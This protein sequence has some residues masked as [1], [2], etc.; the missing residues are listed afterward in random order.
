MSGAEAALLGVGI[1]CNAM[2]IITFAKDSIHVYRNIRDGRA[3]DP[4]LDSYLK[5]SKA[6]FHEMN[7]TAAQIGPLSQTQQQIFDV[8]KKVHDCVDELQQQFARLHVDEGSKRR[9]R[10]RIAAS[11]KS[12]VALWR[13]KELQDAEKNLQRHEQLLHSLLLDRVC[14]QSQAA[15]V[16]S[17]ESFQHL[18]G[19]LQ[20]IISQLAHGSTDVSDLVT[21]FSAN[22]SNQVADEHTTTRT[23]IEDHIASAE[24]TIRQSM[25]QSIDQ[26]RQ[27]LLERE[28]DKAFEKQYERLLSSLRFPDMNRRKHHISSNYP[29]TF[30][31]ILDQD[32]SHQSDCGSSS[33]SDLSDTDSQLSEDTRDSDSGTTDDPGF[34]SF[35]DWLESDSSIFWISGKPG[36]G[37]SFL[38][39]F[40]ASNKQTMDCLKM[41]QSNVRIITHFF[42]KPGQL[43]QR[44]VEGMVL[45]LLYQVMEGKPGL[46]RKLYT[47]QPSVQYK[48]S[49]SDWSLDELTEALIWAL[50]ASPEA[51]CIF[52][53]G[54]DEAKELEHLPWPDWT[55]AQVIHKLL[56]LDD[57]KLCASS[58][59]EH[60]FC[61]FFK[62]ASRL[63]MQQFNNSDITLYVRERLDICGLECRDRDRLVQEIVRKAQGV[64]MWV[65]LIVDRLNPAIR[66]RSANI[67]MLQELLRQTPSDLTTLYTDM[68]GRIGDDGKLPSIQVTAS[69]YFNLLFVAREIDE[70]LSKNGLYSHPA[71]IRMSSLLVMATAAQNQPTETILNTGRV[72]R[73]EDLLAI[74]SRAE[75]ELKLACRGLLEVI[76]DCQDLSFYC[77]GDER[78]CEY[79]STRV[80]FVHRSAFDFLMDTED[81]RECVR[82]CGSSE[83]EQATRLVTAHLIR[84]RFIY[85]DMPFFSSSAGAH[86][87]PL[88]GTYFRNNYLNMAIA[89]AFNSHL[90]TDASVRDGLLDVVKEWQ[91]SRLFYSHLCLLQRDSCHSSSNYLEFEFIEASIV[92]AL[93]DIVLWDCSAH[94]KRLL[95]KYPAPLFLDSIPT[96][97]QAFARCR[98]DPLYSNP[99]AELFKYIL[100]RLRLTAAEEAQHQCAVRDSI[101]ALNCWYIKFLLSDLGLPGR[102][103][104]LVES[105]AFEL[106]SQMSDTLLL[107]EDWHHSL[108]LE[109]HADHRVSNSFVLLRS[110]RLYTFTRSGQTAVVVGN[111]VTAYRLL[112]EALLKHSL[113]PLDVSMPQGVNFRFEVILVTDILPDNSQGMGIDHCYVPETRFHD[114]IEHFLCID[115]YKP[116]PF[117]QQYSWDSWPQVLKCSGTELGSID[118]SKAFS[119]VMQGLKEG[120]GGFVAS[121]QHHCKN[122]K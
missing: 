115:L 92:T 55:N 78:L 75:N 3:P 94:V 74:S 117:K 84:A 33:E 58:R 4:E 27:E 34:D 111:F 45:S 71:P 12:A 61:T 49:H 108:L 103:R 96:M 77:D 23:V 82:A 112:D 25:S 46:C 80:D 5:N 68:W 10:G 21:A 19:A 83:S 13:G 98:G 28:Q 40:L 30:K 110:E 73:V 63:R 53:D 72:M 11:K 107:A 44:N 20:S 70:Y 8:G 52:L 15:E 1:L 93:H 57:V 14:S 60:A 87:V 18:Q 37:K 106:L 59:E 116:I 24:N 38:V 31:W 102:P 6:S 2:Q 17:L 41:W 118:A 7:Q 69:R 105:R 56:K 48:R 42:W 122:Y 85:L 76:G 22:M 65:T 64:F 95:D 51:F 97:R 29:G 36:S 90:F 81:G 39:K 16:T 47:A 113:G 43:L 121:A 89:I 79:N 32:G 9:F 109:F 67:E 88:Y 54:L 104:M 86:Q 100:R 119:H 66:Q 120:G 26:L 99:F 62:D 91:L 35:A 114:Q 50:E 101:R